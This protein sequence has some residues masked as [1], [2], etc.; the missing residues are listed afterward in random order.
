MA[1]KNSNK[2]PN[3]ESTQKKT[4]NP[5][6]DTSK[7]FLIPTLLLHL[8]N[9]NLHGYELM[10]QMTQFGIDSIDK[11]N[12]YRTLRQLE[13]DN[14]V[15]SEWDTTSNGPA[16]RIYS[17]TDAGEKYLGIWANTLS[18]QQKMLNQFFNLYNPFFSSYTSSQD[19]KADADDE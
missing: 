17:I 9:L 2:N 14:M 7:N 10:Q 16:K 4:K 18:H 19:E 8:S 13:K 12:F 1:A 3:T 6:L 11:G 15:S 5:N